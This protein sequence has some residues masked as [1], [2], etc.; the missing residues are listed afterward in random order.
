MVSLLFN[1]F[2][3]ELDNRI[4]YDIIKRCIKKLKPHKDDRNYGFKSYHF[5]IG[6]N[7]LF[8]VLAMLFNAM[9]T[10]GV[11]R[12]DLWLLT[13]ISISKN[14]RGSMNSSDK[15]RCISLSNSICK[16]YDYVFF[17]LNID[18][19]K[20]DDMQFGLTNIHPPVVC[21]AVYV[22]TVNHYMN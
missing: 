22:E 6:W 10:H 15:Y 16:L 2:C 20:T 8:I 3:V 17:P 12:E 5:I 14:N 13:I 9:L 1:A 19:L 11:S 18:Y 4:N 21:T 7:K